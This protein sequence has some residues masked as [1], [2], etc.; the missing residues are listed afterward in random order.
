MTAKSVQ[1]NPTSLWGEE[2]ELLPATGR[3]F[4]LPRAT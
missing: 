3:V 1:R 4:T 2:R